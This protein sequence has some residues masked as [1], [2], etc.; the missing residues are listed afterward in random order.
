MTELKSK[1]KYV[2]YD[3]SINIIGGL[4][5]SS[6]IYKAIQSHFHDEDSIS[7]LISGRNEFNL[8]TEKSRT[9]VERAVKSTFLQFKNDNHRELMKSIFVGN[10]QPLEK[11]LILFWQFS[12]NNRLFNDIS[13]RVFIKAYFSGRANLSKE[14]IIAYLKEFLAQN[15]ELDLQWSEST[16]N[17]LSTKYL[18]FMTKIN[19]LEGV[20]TKSFRHLKTSA[21]S[22]V[23]FLYFAKLHDPENSDILS[24]D[25]LP[26]SLVSSEDIQ[27]RLKKLSLKGFFNMSFNGVALNI[28]LTHSYKGICD[29]LYNR[30][31][32]KV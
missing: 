2:T 8:R 5:D 24:N 26:L 28:E 4:K 16:I 25:M 12:I 29:A 18:N 19:F 17:T 22:L 27:D 14:D 7:Q 3:T 31:S 20:R 9:R 15:K 23:L 6:V 30:P 13:S 21:E 11:E 1:N 10:A 32:T